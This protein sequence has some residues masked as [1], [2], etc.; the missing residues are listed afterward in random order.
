[1]AQTTVTVFEGAR[2]IVG[3]GR[4]IDNATIV[5]QGDRHHAGRTGGVDQGAGRRDAR[6]PRR[7]DA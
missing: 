2:V 3:D 1:M 6:E 5:V 4:I 7:Q